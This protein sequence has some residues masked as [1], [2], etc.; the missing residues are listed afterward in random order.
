MYKHQKNGNGFSS[1]IGK[2]LLVLT[3]STGISIPILAKSNPAP[4]SVQHNQQQKVEVRGTVKDIHGD[5]LIGVSVVVAGTGSGTIT[6]I[7]GNFSIQVEKLGVSMEFTYMGYKKA[8]HKAQT[9]LMVVL[10]T[11]NHLLD[12]VI[13]VGYGTMKKSDLTGSITSVKSDA[14]KKQSVTN[15]AEALQGQGTGLM[16]SSNS[17][18]PGGS[19]NVKVRGIGTINDSN[20]LFVVDGVPMTTIEFINPA[21]IQHVEVL[22]DASSAAIYGSR[23]A[24]GVI[25]ITTKQGEVGKTTVSFDSYWGAS[26]MLDNTKMMS[27]SQWYDFQE[28]L[29]AAKV[30]EGGTGID[31]SQVNRDTNTNWM[32]EVSQSAF[33]QSYNLAISGGVKDNI[34]YNFTLG[35]ID[36]EGTIKRTNYE[37]ISFRQNIVKNIY[38]DRVKVG[39][40]MSYAQARRKKVLEG[41]NTVGIVNTALK[42]EPV[43]PVWDASRNNYGSSPFIDYPNPVAAI[44][45]SHNTDKTNSLFG[46][47]YLDAEIIPG[48]TFRGSFGADIRRTDGYVFEPTY[49][50][51]AAQNVPVSSVGRGNYKFD[52]Y[53][54]EYTLSY[55]KTFAEKHSI[56]AVVGFTEE[57]NKY[58]SLYVSKKDLPLNNPGDAILDAAIDKNSALGEGYYRINTLQSWL[59]RV[60]YNYDNRYLFTASMRRDGSSKF[61]SGNRW[62]NFPS[63][64]VGWRL[65]QEKFMQNLDL[66]WLSGLKFRVGWGR[67]G[68][69]KV[70]PYQFRSYLNGDIQ[71]SYLWGTDNILS[72]GY[73]GVAQGNPDIKWESTDNTN[74]GIDMSFLDSRLSLTAE[75]YYRK[76]KDMLIKEPIPGFFGYES[77]SDVNVGS[78]KNYGFEFDVNWSDRVNDFD[79]QIGFNLSTLKNEVTSVGDSGQIFG[80]TIRNGNAT[81]TQVG[82]PIG[83]FYGYKTDGVVKNAAQLA[84]VQKYQPN[85]QLGDVIFQDVNKDGRLNTNDRTTLGSPIPK[86]IMGM[87]IGLGYKNFDFSMLINGSF[88]NK[89]FNAMRYFTYD[90]SGVTNKDRDMMN[91]WTPENPNTNVPR[92]TGRDTNDN[93]R[94][95]DRYV[96]NGSYVRLRNVQLGYT[97]P[98]HLTTKIMLQKVRVYVSAQNLLTITNYSGL[99]PEIGE[100]ITGSLNRGVDIGTYPASRTIMGGLNVTF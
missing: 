79:Y 37:R 94:I 29:N 23:A 96:E 63:V 73:V 77:G 36:Q 11:D 72:S 62:G 74:V 92:L 88:G 25:L 35:Y 19:I 13:V 8:I 32:K 4:V 10:E 49:S 40:N 44:D 45:H 91:F 30:A 2:A 61:A 67:I 33:T 70:A 48:L 75:Y 6:D 76:T 95:S 85:A 80:G 15:A 18:A 41:S 21:D 43:I 58:E 100:T 90:L 7:D 12:E 97:L 51:S 1:R 81:I 78:L 64:S 3:L 57:K 17:G 46:N 50:V 16:V 55:N 86:V 47:V 66:N 71:Y 20:P 89:I 22:K 52:T 38:K 98:K 60:N 39:T 28:S 53:V 42:L 65:D 24:N 5:V 68:N 34:T 82:S 26:K 87:T 84:E 69:D 93:I 27:G 56:N 99:D 54:W 14:I 59:G 83:S 31:L 9:N